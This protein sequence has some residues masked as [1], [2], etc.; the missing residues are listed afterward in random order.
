MFKNLSLSIRIR[1]VTIQHC[2][3][4]KYRRFSCKLIFLNCIKN[5]HKVNR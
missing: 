1:Y 4:K 2:E 3:L 5:K